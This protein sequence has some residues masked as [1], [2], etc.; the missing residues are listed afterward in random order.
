MI[1]LLENDVV[2]L[3]GREII[4]QDQDYSIVIKN[5]IGKKVTVEQAK[6]GTLTYKILNT[7]NYSEGV[8]DLQ[9]KF[10]SITSQDITYVGIIQ[11]ARA[12]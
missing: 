8:N 7:H 10:D 9:L 11:T 1:K 3:N 4:S 5:K 6:K 2:V 12:G